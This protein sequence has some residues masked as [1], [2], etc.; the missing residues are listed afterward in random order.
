MTVISCSFSG[1][2][3]ELKPREQRNE[4]KV[5]AALKNDPMVSTWDMGEHGL[6]KTI[7]ELEDCGF[8]KSENCDYPWCKYSVTDK[9]IE[10]LKE[11]PHD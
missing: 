8:V 3:A 5:L 10:K 9:G 11:A 7:K 4:M 2:V 1:S 6:W